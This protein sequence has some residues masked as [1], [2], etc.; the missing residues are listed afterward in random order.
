MSQIK[1]EEVQVYQTDS[2][3]S[4][5][6]ISTIAS[7]VLWAEF[8]GP[9]I[10]KV[11]FFFLFMAFYIRNLQVLKRGIWIASRES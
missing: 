1:I 9:G 11:R 6:P 7:N 3:L 8:T 4:V 5:Q 10:T 2:F